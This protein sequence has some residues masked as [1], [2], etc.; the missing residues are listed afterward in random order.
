M[1][2]SW[3]SFFIRSFN[4]VVL[5]V[6]VSLGLSC[7]VILVFQTPKCFKVIFMFRFT[8]FVFRQH[9]DFSAVSNSSR[10]VFYIQKALA[11]SPFPKIM[12]LSLR[13]FCGTLY[14]TISAVRS[15]LLVISDLFLSKPN[16]F[17]MNPICWVLISGEP[18]GLLMVLVLSRKLFSGV[19]QGSVTLYDPLPLHLK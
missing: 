8:R 5:K 7:S 10:F 18:W 15:N 4:D 12:S 17:Q 1:Y 2:F 13:F 11:G 6:F 3:T 14:R 19:Q 16:S 9:I